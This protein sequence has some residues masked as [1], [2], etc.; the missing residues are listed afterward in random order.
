MTPRPPPAFRAL[1]KAKSDEPIVAGSAVIIGP[2]CCA[3]VLGAVDPSRVVN[4]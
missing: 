2:T 4:T 3:C 1:T